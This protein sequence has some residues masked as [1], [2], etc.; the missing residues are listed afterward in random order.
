MSISNTHRLLYSIENRYFQ[1][2]FFVNSFPLYVVIGIEPNQALN[3][4]N[5]Q[6]KYFMKIY[7]KN[8]A[9]ESCKIFVKDALDE[10]GIPLIKVELGKMKQRKMCPMMRKR[11]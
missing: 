5:N 11:N 4:K 6:K 1:I 7:V 9:C 10:L 2:I 3:D 8:M